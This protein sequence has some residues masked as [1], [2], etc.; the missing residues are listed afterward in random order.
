MRS[1][2]YTGALGG[3][4]LAGLFLVLSVTAAAD[5]DFGQPVM[6]DIPAQPLDQAITELARQSGLSVG[7][8]AALL[9]GKLAPA[10]RGEYTPEAALNALLSGSGITWRL[11]GDRIVTLTS[12]SDASDSVRLNPVTVEGALSNPGARIASPPPAY[13]GGQVA[14]GGRLGM[15]GNTD[16]M[17]APLSITSYTEQTISDRQARS[18]ADVLVTE[19]AVRKASARTNIGE[20]FTVRGFPVASQDV[21]LQGMYGLMPFFRVPIEMAER[22]EVLKGPSALLNG[23]PPSGDIGG[24]INIVPKRAGPEPLTRM[25][26]QYLSD[27]VIGGHVDV[28]RRFGDDE[29]LGARVNGVIRGGDTRIDDQSTREGLGSLGL[30]YLGERLRLSGDV[31]YQNQIIDGVVRQFTISPEVTRIPDAPDGTTSYPGGWTDNDMRD[32]TGVVRVE[33]DLDWPATLYAGAGTRRSRMDA[34]AGNPVLS[35]NDG[36]YV[37]TPGWQLFDVDSSSF[38]TGLSSAFTT[39]PVSHRVTAGATRVRQDSDIFFHTDFPP[40]SSNLYAPV[41][42]PDP[43]LSG[44]NVNKNRY[45]ETELT[46]YAVA[47]TLSFSDDR[48]ALTVGARRQQVAARNFDFVTGQPTGPKYDENAVTPVA[49]LV[50]KPRENVSL[51]ASYI[52][53]LSQGPTAPNDPSLTN[54]GEVFPP[55][56]TS[57]VEAGVKVDWGR[58]AGTLALYELDK[59]NGIRAGDRFAV[60]GEQRHRGVELNLFGQLT[61]RIRLLGGVAYIDSTLSRTESGANEGNTA[62]GVPEWQVNLGGEWDPPLLPGWSLN[63]LMLHTGEQY[64]D[65]ANNLE[66]P[67]WTRIDVGARYRTRVSGNPVV[68]RASVQNVLD[69][70]YWNVANAGYLYLGDARTLLLSATIDF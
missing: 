51:Y 69:E 52:E 11:T 19:P 2:H 34:V 14:A 46:S 7:G 17:D 16:I 41:D 31:I 53:G 26:T 60:D 38:E 39:G 47:D 44:I 13:A 50:V 4:F 35:S 66:I 59:P 36:D 70:S 42:S 55:V 49:G 24:A 1:L 23:M 21:A 37:S 28:G 68:L 40:R 43:D 64:V 58:L 12:A 65:Q 9:R 25:T 27:S 61:P 5:S 8:D 62:V 29:A 15:L 63:L 20:D 30:D 18:I 3:A 48:I 6:L 22:V 57:Q 10:L 54:P 67:E 56:E 32:T 33:Y 45:Q